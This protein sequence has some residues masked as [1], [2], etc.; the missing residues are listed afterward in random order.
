[1][2]GAAFLFSVVFLPLFLV[3][4]VGVSATRAGLTMMPLTMG[5]VAGSVLTGQIVARFG[6]SRRLMLGSLVLLGIGFAVMAFTLTPDSTQTDLTLKM[7]L[8][9]LGIGPQ[10]PLYTLVI[11]HAARPEDIGVVTAA[12]TFSRSLG[13]VIGV[14]A[15]GTIFASV[16]AASVERRVA[17]ILSELPTHV[18]A[19]VSPTIT[20]PPGASEL[21]SVAYD[22]AGAKA[23]IGD[24]LAG[25]SGSH[26][27]VRRGPIDEN[28][29]T[30]DGSSDRHAALGA[31]D[32]IARAHEWAFTD[33]IS[34][35]YRGA[36]GL[37]ALALLLSIPIP[38]APL[39]GVRAPRQSVEVA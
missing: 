18:R 38:D 13:Q 32:E 20:P 22:T 17:A 16:F 36:L 3:N 27:E 19:L 39:H 10:F 31:V 6:H 26:V 29:A 5:I 21:M 7:I 2:L 34:T 33:A 9:G 12:T 35:L 30:G 37:I 23:Q 28:G 4:V 8:V 25:R 1:V 14:A 24:L 11:Q 15:F